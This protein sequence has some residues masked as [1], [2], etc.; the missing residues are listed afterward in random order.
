MLQHS[1]MAFLCVY[2]GEGDLKDDDSEEA[3]ARLRLKRKLH[4]K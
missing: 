1:N 3:Q 4:E 2:P